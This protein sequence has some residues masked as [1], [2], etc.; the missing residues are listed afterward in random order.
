M[1]FWEE[2]GDKILVCVNL[3]T[4][5]ICSSVK[6][7]FSLLCFKIMLVSTMIL[8]M[9]V[10]WCIVRQLAI[11][12]SFCCV[13]RP[14]PNSFMAC[15]SSHYCS[16][17]MWLDLGVP[18]VCTPPPTEAPRGIP[19]TWSMGMECISSSASWRARCS[20]ISIQHGVSCVCKTNCTIWW[21]NMILT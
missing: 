4:F 16:P 12:S 5:L 20:C 18:E 10:W 9:D 8:H 17:D 6:K 1:D 3:W 7:L 2:E 11:V 14:L 19:R 13:L 21:V 15:V